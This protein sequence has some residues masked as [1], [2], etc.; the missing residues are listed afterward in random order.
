MISCPMKENTHNPL[1]LV[2]MVF[3]CFF[4]RYSCC[5]ALAKKKIKFPT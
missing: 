3:L 2:F 4:V 1:P 5:R